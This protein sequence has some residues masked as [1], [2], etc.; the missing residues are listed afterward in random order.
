MHTFTPREYLL[1]DMANQ[2]GKDKKTFPQRIAWAKSIKRPMSK[3][4]FAKKPYQYAAA[5]LAL[6]QADRGEVIGHLVGLD[7]SASGIALMATMMGCETTAKNCGIIGNKP[8]DIY[9][10]LTDTMQEMTDEDVDVERA[11]SKYAM[12]T[13][14]YGSEATPKH[15][16]GDGDMLNTFYGAAEEVAPGA[17][18][19]LEILLDSWQ[20]YATEHSWRMPDGF[21]VKIPVLQ[22]VQ[23]KIEVDEIEG[24]P[25][26]QYVHYVN[27]GTETGLSVAANGV[28]SV[29][30][31]IVREITR[32]CNYDKSDLLAVRRMLKK[33]LDNPKATERTTV[34]LYEKLYWAHG[35]ASLACVDSMLASG[36]NGYSLTFKTIIYE[37]IEDV[38]TYEPFDMI[39]IHD[40]FKCHPNHVNRMR[41]TYIGI[42]AEIADSDIGQEIV[43]QIRKDDTFTLKKLSENLGDLIREGEYPI[44]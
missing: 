1:I 20:P 8:S 27:E 10:V 12:M 3:V 31:F 5:V 35:F 22:K 32:R 2:Y 19:L 14:Y 26:I 18:K 4:G 39:Q 24:H 23:S 42:L 34:P 41:E 44:G 36:I 28:H 13:R 37:L 16:F 40:E 9:T 25:S 7:A 38:L 43:R 11:D 15:I 30:G 6:Q 21:M 33:D 17:N 29:D